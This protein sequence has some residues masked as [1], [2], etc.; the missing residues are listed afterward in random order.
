MQMP[1]PSLWTF[2]G[3]FV[4]RQ[5]AGRGLVPGAPKGAAPAVVVTGAGDQFGAALPTPQRF[6]VS[7]S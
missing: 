6:G 1:H 3:S 4:P 5:R 7:G 2:R